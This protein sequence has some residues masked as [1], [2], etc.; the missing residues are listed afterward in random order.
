MN[1]L[2]ETL[3]AIFPAWRV[4][5]K[6]E[7]SISNVKLIWTE[8]FIRHKIETGENL[9]IDQGIRLAKISESDFFPSVGKF[10]SWCKEDGLMSESEA[11]ERFNNAMPS[12]TYVE[13]VTRSRCGYEAKRMSQ[14]KGDRLFIKTFREVKSSP[15]IQDR[16]LMIDNKQSSKT[17]FTR[18]E[19][20]N[21]INRNGLDNLKKII[22]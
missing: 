15:T 20:Q 21:A 1:E 19:N 18:K 4:S 2:F 3:E 13:Q 8:E 7:K 17:I 5:M 16:T 10:I 9:N 12:L 22:K 11:L 14:E 6:S